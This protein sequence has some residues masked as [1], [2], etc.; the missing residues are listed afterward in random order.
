MWIDAVCVLLPIDHR[1][2][3][4]LNEL[5]SIPGEWS[6]H[7]RLRLAAC[8]SLAD[9]FAE[10]RCRRCD[11]RH[12]RRVSI[13]NGRLTLVTY[14]RD[15]FGFLSDVPSLISFFILF[16]SIFIIN[17][18]TNH[19][20]SKPLH[21]QTSVISSFMK[22]EQGSRS[23]RRRQEVHLHRTWDTETCKNDQLDNTM[24]ATRVKSTTQ[25][26]PVLLKAVI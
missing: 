6:V 4:L 19:L 12:A 13:T 14:S 2:S 10:G 22:V 18:H 11:T 16:E 7:L 9:H 8:C 25:V 15:L 26:K 24:S 5:I 3:C 17:I 20:K 23:L 21:S 1:P